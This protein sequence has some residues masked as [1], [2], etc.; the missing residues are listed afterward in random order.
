MVAIHSAPASPTH[1]EAVATPGASPAPLYSPQE[2]LTL[3]KFLAAAGGTRAPVLSDSQARSLADTLAQALRPQGVLASPPKLFSDP[4][5]L[6]AAQARDLAVVPLVPQ[7]SNPSAAPDSQ[8]SLAL[9]S[10]EL[11][12][13]SAHLSPTPSASTLP[14][15]VPKLTDRQK[16]ERRVRKIAR[17]RQLLEAE[18]AQLVAT[19]D[20]IQGSLAVPVTISAPT[21]VPH[22]VPNLVPAPTQ[23]AARPA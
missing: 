10:Q 17:A 6:P 22:S 4:S 7:P 23:S 13:P 14:P 21:S 12:A 19:E 2:L 18:M 8:P 15:V 16:K 5:V 3:Q 1:A 9:P 20:R 11:G